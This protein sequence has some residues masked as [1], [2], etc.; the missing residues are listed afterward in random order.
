MDITLIPLNTTSYSV[1]ANT[2]GQSSSTILVD[3][4]GN[5]FTKYVHTITDGRIS[6]LMI[7]LFPLFLLFRYWLIQNPF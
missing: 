6:L 4:D 7:G 2:G 3:A 1:T 5:T